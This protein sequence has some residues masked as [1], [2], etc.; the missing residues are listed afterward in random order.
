[1]KVMPT[2]EHGITA[3]LCK[4]LMALELHSMNLEDDVDALGSTTFTIRSWKKKLIV[5]GLCP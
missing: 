5:A 1:M 4:T 3:E 2:P